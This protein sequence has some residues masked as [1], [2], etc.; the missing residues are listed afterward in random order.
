MQPPAIKDIKGMEENCDFVLQD[1]LK[2]RHSVFAPSDKFVDKISPSDM[3]RLTPT[4]EQS[5]NAKEFIEAPL[6]MNHKVM[7][8]LME[9]IASVQE[10]FK[11][12]KLFNPKYVSQGRLQIPREVYE[13]II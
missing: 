10:Q 5:A 6:T 3:L 4:Q 1:I 13:R 11:D 9:N 12:F 8:N 2:M 7:K